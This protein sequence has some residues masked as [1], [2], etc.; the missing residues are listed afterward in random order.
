M[1]EPGDQPKIQGL[2]NMTY[3]PEVS[4][5]EVTPDMMAAGLDA[6]LSYDSRFE[7]AEDAVRRIWVRMVAA[8][9]RDN[10]V[11]AAGGRRNLVPR[12]R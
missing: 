12:S 7:D 4:A 10:A 8:M 6:W 2:E 9:S 3:R 1:V 11:S 5:I